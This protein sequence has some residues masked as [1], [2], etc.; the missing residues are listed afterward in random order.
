M[1]LVLG[2][3]TWFTGDADAIGPSDE[4]HGLLINSHQSDGVDVGK[5][6]AVEATRPDLPGRRS[7][8]QRLRRTPEEQPGSGGPGR[9]WP[10]RAG[11]RTHL[12]AKV[13][14]TAVALGRSVELCDLRDVEAPH[15]LLPYR[16]A[17][18][19]AERHAHAVL[20]LGVSN[21]LVQQVP[22][23]LADV[24]HN[25]ERTGQQAPTSGRRSRSEPGSVAAVTLTVQL[26]LAQSSQKREAE[27]FFLMTTVMP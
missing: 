20:P 8:Q 22:A 15:K 25:L 4:L 14:Q 24:L 11:P 21:G 27:N 7:E 17:Q 23:D 13:A 2:G 1:V 26:Y 16:L 6:L 12:V 19:V 9:A 18:A 10:G 3:V 5:D